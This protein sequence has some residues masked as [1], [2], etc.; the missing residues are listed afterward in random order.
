MHVEE[1]GQRE[2]LAALVL[3]GGPGSGGSPLQRSF[4]DPAV[5]RIVC[6][7]QRGAGMSTPRG[8][9]VE[10]TLDHLLAD[11]RLLRE[12]LEVDRWIVVGGS[13]GATLALLHAIDQP[14]AV[15]GLVL[16]NPFLARGED[17]SRFFASEGWEDWRGDALLESLGDLFVNGSPAAQR[18]AAARWWRVEQQLSGGDARA[19]QDAA[20][21]ERLADRYRIQSHYLRHG[22]W[23]APPLLEQCARVPSVPV[24]VLQG[25]ED[26]VCPPEGAQSLAQALGSRATLQWVEGAGHDPSHPAMAQAMRQAL[27]HCAAFRAR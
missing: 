14:H 27:Q 2:G 5:W 11:L 16:R 6:P 9:V 3:H 18:E 19:H 15:A 22:C 23:I 7:D 20:D 13:W 4:F 24:V 17:I 26:R 21:L 25:T 12:Q 10:N 1:H 8:S